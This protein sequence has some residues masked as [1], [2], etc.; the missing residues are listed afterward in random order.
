MTR[1]GPRTCSWSGHSEPRAK[2]YGATWAPTFVV[3]TAGD[4]N[5]IVPAVR[6]VL[7]EIDS[8]LPISNISSLDDLV[9]S[10]V[11]GN[12]FNML[13]LGIF[14]GVALLLA[15]AGIYG[16]L[17]YTVSQ[18]TSE[19]GV[20]VALGASPERVLQQMVLEGMRPVAWGI[21]IGLAAAIGLSRFL[22]TLL[23]GIEPT[24]P[25][26]YG[27]VALMLA[28]AALAACYVPARRGLRVDPRVALA[29]E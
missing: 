24:D 18:R 21:A 20:R 17:A 25:I 3:H 1:R 14:A 5:T 19:I 22:S 15:L 16:V 2:P 10:S 13:L 29:A 8:N 11:A 26:T 6:T 4:P 9:I 28:V 27:G 23:F 7:G 12:R